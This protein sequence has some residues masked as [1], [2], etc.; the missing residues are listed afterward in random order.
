MRT[1]VSTTLVRALWASIASTLRVLPV[2]V[3]TPIYAPSALCHPT[4]FGSVLMPI[5]GVLLDLAGVVYQAE[6]LTHDALDA[7]ARIRESGLKIRFVTNTTRMAKRDILERLAGFG[8]DVGSHELFT[9]TVAAHTWLAENG[10]SPELL[11][12]PALAHEFDDLPPA[13]AMAVVVGD[14]GERFTYASMNRAFRT[15]VKGGRLLA[16][17][18]NRAFRDADGNLS[19]D[20]GPFVDALEFAT[21]QT[22]VVVGKPSAGIFEAAAASMGCAM[23]NAVMVGDDADAD[24]AGARLAGVGHALLVRTGKFREGDDCRYDPPPSAVVADLAA[25]AEWIIAHRT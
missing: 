17:A 3:A 8:L 11:V 15:L 18:K 6:E 10:C 16:L 5:H 9:P 25:A 21:G 12:H 22:A 1:S 14:A 7:I 13:S 24:V 23:E 20:A 4:D 2:D 19:L